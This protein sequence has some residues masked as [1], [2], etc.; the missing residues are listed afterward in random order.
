[1]YL[2]R[3]EINPYRRETMKVFD[4]P[5][6]MHAS[7]MAGF[8]S[9]DSTPD[10]VLWRVDRLGPSVYVLVQ[11][12]RKPDFSHMVEQYGRPETMQ[13]WDTME[14]D[15]FLQ[16]IETG[17]EWRFRLT[18]NP[19]H[20]VKDGK[21][22]ESRGK[23]K[24]HVTIEQQKKWLIDRSQ[25]LGFSLTKLDADN[26]NLEI[27]QRDIKKFMREGKETTVSMATFEGV[28][29]VEDKEVFLNSMVNG[30]GRAKSY[31]CGMITVARI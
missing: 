15:P 29:K 2:S 21:D 19:V 12:R 6:L 5:Q 20:S 30:I 11:S 31:G 24:A 27:K 9:F 10:R 17:Q 26:Y 13:G 28:L 8:S 18:A 23:V 14:Y 22:T 1:M 4:S 16:K 25:K 7:V 3:V